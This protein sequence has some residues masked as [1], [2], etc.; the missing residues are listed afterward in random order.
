MHRCHYYGISQDK[1]GDQH[2]EELIRQNINPPVVNEG[3]YGQNDA[4][5]NG[6]PELHRAQQ[7]NEHE[8]APHAPVQ[9]M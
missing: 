9:E 1:M 6:G 8:M 3:V 2:N 7:D 5:D 4:G